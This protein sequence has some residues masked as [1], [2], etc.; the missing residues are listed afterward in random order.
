MTAV[1]PQFF[2]AGLDGDI[3]AILLAQ[4]RNL[5]T[6]ASTAIEGNTLTLGDTAFVLEEGLTIAGKPLRDHQEVYGHAKGIEVIYRLLEV[7]QLQESDIFALHRVVLTEAI[8]DIYKPVGA[9]KNET[10][11]TTLVGPDGRQHWREFPEPE[12][13]SGLMSQW[14]NAF[15][16]WYGQP[17]TMD[18]AGRAYADI[19]LDFVTIHPFFDG[20]GRMARL[21]ANLPVLRAGFPPIVVPAEARQGYKKA[22]SDY[23]QTIP[24][25]KSLSELRTLPGNRE[26]AR[27]QELCGSY[28]ESTMTLV[29]EARQA[30]ER[31]RVVARRNPDTPTFPG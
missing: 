9:W 2:T 13:I 23:Q 22:I 14:L 30:Q 21:L 26:R 17:L 5:W 15:N 12:H 18:A 27:F 1:R 29:A 4:V 24:N 20:N 6:H 7:T 11:F 8:T 3:K 31:K 10:N 16:T 19:H 25:L 28:W